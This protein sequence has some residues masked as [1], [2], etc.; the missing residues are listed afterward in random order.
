MFTLILNLVF[1]YYTS[2][3]A[4]DYKGFFFDR[5]RFD[6]KSLLVFFCTTTLNRKI[7]PIVLGP[8]RLK[9]HVWLLNVLKSTR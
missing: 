2:N 5:N 7:Q 8:Y 1:S 6:H 9:T 3:S 4:K